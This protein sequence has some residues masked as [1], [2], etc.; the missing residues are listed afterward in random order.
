MKAAALVVLF[1]MTVHGVVGSDTSDQTAEFRLIVEDGDFDQD[2]DSGHIAVRIDGTAR[3][4]LAVEPERTAVNWLLLVDVSLSSTRGM[5]VGQTILVHDFAGNVRAIERGFV[6]RLPPTDRLLVS[7]FAGPQFWRH[8]A[9]SMDREVQRAAVRGLV[10][11]V[12]PGY[13]IGPSPIWDAV[14]SAAR[15]LAPEE[16]QRAIVL[17][18][19][20]H[21]SGNVLALIDAAAES[22]RHDVPVFVMQELF[23]GEGTNADFRWGQ[24]ETVLRRLATSTGG[25]FR[26]NDAPKRFGWRDPLPDY[27][28]FIDAMQRRHTVHV[29]VTGL[30]SGRYDLKVEP[31]REGLTVHKPE[32]IWVR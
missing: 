5:R 3:R 18:T 32:W 25:M 28:H 23:W 15:L 17:F 22:V 9:F 19:D 27:G 4:V 24:G 31:R 20:G 10:T 16:R 14:A 11:P 21:A 12:E 26:V 30:A 6:E 8:G 29:D 2:L 1:V 7:R 13:G